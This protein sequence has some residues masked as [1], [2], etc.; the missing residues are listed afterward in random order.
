MAEQ[1][2][3]Q[4]PPPSLM[5]RLARLVRSEQL[6]LSFLALLIGVAAA[7]GSIGFRE[8]IVLIQDFAFAPVVIASV[9]GTIVAR[10]HLGDYPAFILGD[11]Q[12]A[13]FLELPAFAL[14]GVV[15]AIVSVIFMRSIVFTQS[16]WKRTFVPTWLRLA[17]GGAAVG[18]LALV[19]PE[20][21]GVGYEATDQALHSA[22]PLWLLLALIGG[23]IAATSFSLGSGF[24]GGIFSPSLFIGAMIGGA[25][26][27][28]AA[29]VMP[30]LSSSPGVYA[31]AGMSAVAG[32]V[33]GAP[34]STILIVFE[35]TGQMGARS[36]LHLQLLGRGLDLVES[37]AAGL[38]QDIHVSQIM[39]RNFTSLIANAGIAEIKRIL[40]E[41]HDADIV[42]T[43]DAGRLLGM[44]G[45]AEIRGVAFE[46]GLDNLLYAKDLSRTVPET[47]QA[48]DTLTTV[49]HLMEHG[50]DR[51]RAGG[52]R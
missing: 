25:F 17:I 5:Q 9:A 48:E 29:S 14:L 10:I 43:D 32:A 23:K 44:V 36:F 52:C 22:L 47:L 3:P 16:V 2:P 20:I 45:F 27:L 7:Y 50:R 8:L 19:L 38:M 41:D 42:V 12:L 4:I 31:I 24:V 37:R 34:I 40:S 28:I 33:F 30:E 13:S 18:G 21:L 1:A 11:F 49:L 39:S 6:V 15:C 35:L 46:T 51:P 26:G